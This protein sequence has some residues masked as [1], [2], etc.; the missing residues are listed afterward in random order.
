MLVVVLNSS[1]I[2]QILSIIH[3]DYHKADLFELRIDYLINN[4]LEL[5]VAEKIASISKIYNL[6]KF[7]N[8]PII[9]TLRSGLDSH[10][11]GKF[12]GAE[13]Q[14]LSLIL[15]FAKLKPDYFDLED[16]IN[17][18]FLFLF[19][20]LYPEIKIILSYHDFNAAPGTRL[21]L[22]KINNIFN[23]L[24]LNNL[25]LDI[26]DN[27]KLVFYAHSSL[28]NLV[29]LKFLD[30][31]NNH[32][33]FKNKLTIHCMGELG[34]ASRILGQRF[35]NKFTYCISS[36]ISSFI[37]SNLAPG[38]LT[39]DELLNIYNF[40]LINNLT[41]IFALIGN[42]VEQSVGHVFHNNF[43]KKNNI[44]AIYI[45]LLISHSELSEFFYWFDQLP[46]DG[47][48]VT[49]PFKTAVSNFLTVSINNKINAI[50]TIRKNKMTNHLEGIN[51]DGIG[52]LLALSPE[53]NFK[54]KN[55]LI[56]GG[57]GAAL[58]IM[59]ELRK[60]KINKLV[61]INRDEEKIKKI[62]SEYNY[63]IEVIGL[64]KFNPDLF[65][66]IKFDYI[67]NAI[68]FS[69]FSGFNISEDDKFNL[70]QKINNIVNCYSDAKTIYMNINYHDDI[71]N[72]NNRLNYQIVSGY[73]MYVKQAEKQIEYWLE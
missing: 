14:R 54:N 65:S 60:H 44:N 34:Q 15:E 5:N 52:A 55:I 10:N 18:D 39:I 35:N 33:Q 32:S 13:S 46:I 31:I 70:A 73:K 61:V 49:M 62:S 8:L 56:I 30:N 42:P 68:S 41:K 67:I 26:I 36:C 25:V 51:T 72:K 12:T 11:N 1:D 48:S 9:F 40:K 71:K 43:Y 17:Q 47:L 22:D 38:I 69:V 53:N 4:T 23:N 3:N 21:D 20:K 45:K 27:Y 19:N 37:S 28:D 6:V 63:N 50:N 7:Y 24:V 2:N 66:F 57:G 64:D 29:V 58:G 16:Y 59:A